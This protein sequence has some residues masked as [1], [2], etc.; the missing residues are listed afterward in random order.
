VDQ[1]STGID[2][3]FSMGSLCRLMALLEDSMGASPI[4]RVWQWR[5]G[6]VALSHCLSSLSSLYFESTDLDNNYGL[7][8]CAARSGTGRMEALPQ[9]E[10]RF[11][12]E[13]S[14]L[15]MQLQLRYFLFS[16]SFL[17]NNSSLA[18]KPA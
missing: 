14:A 11:F 5:H 4:R 2:Q 7:S 17:S 1:L 9:G 15:S 12:R 16:I 13:R 10:A 3:S 18:V 8:A 6:A